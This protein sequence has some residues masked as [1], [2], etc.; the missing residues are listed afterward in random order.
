MVRRSALPAV[1][2]VA[3]TAAVACGGASDTNFDSG[4]GSAAEGG[5]AGASSGGSS[6]GGSAQGGTSGSA[7]GSGGSSRGGDSS[8]GSQNG[9]S[10]TG[11]S[12][13][14]GSATGGS[15]TGGDSGSAS[16]GSATGGTDAG[17]GTAGAP[18]GAGPGG[19]GGMSG[20]AGSGGQDCTTI[21]SNAQ[22][23]LRSAQACNL[24][25]SSRQQCQGRVEDLCGC[26]V[27]VNDPE[28]TATKSY[29]AQRD[30]AI[31]CG[32]ACL[33]IE[34]PAPTTPMCAYQGAMGGPADIIAAPMYCSWSPR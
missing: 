17:G 26:T 24:A 21:V 11:G 10:A 29:L 28:S 23:A 16:G 32:V 27:P 30:A 3:T 20:S 33:A 9:G 19:G 6:Q 5:T 34:C 2:F 13:T 1:L 14:G 31:R 12:A 18:G 22:L 15:A 4:D 7:S 8:G 25:I